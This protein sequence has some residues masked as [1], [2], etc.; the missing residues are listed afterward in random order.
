[1]VHDRHTQAMENLIKNDEQITG[2]LQQIGLTP[3]EA[4][5]LFDGCGSLKDIAK[6]DLGDILDKTSLDTLTAKQIVE[7]FN[8]K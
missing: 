4:N 1:M 3:H 7:V 5:I 8:E 6:C 2:A